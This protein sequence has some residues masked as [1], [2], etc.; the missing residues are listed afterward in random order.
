V[1]GVGTLTTGITAEV[2]ADGTV[3]RG[4]ARVAW[5]VRSG[6]DW[7]VPGGDSKTRQS[8]PHPAPVV[9]TAFR[10][11]NGDAV[12]RVYAV[13]DGDG[14]VVVIEV[15]ND[16][17]E[18]I[19]IGFV[20]E[21]PGMVT[22][23][24][25]GW[26]V[27][28]SLVLVPARRAGAVE[29]DHGLVFPVPHRTK[30]RVALARTPLDVTALADADA[31]ARAWDRMLDRGLR[32][33][34]PEELQDRVDAARV[35]RLLSAPSADAFVALE[36]WGFDEDAAEMWA[37]L[38]M[39]A[40]RAARRASKT[41]AGGLLGDVR[42]ALVAE[43]GA[44]IEFVP[45][46]RTEWLGRNIGAHDIPL[47]RGACSFAVRWHGSRPAVLWD[48]PP[49]STVR[50]PALDPGWSSTEPA[51]EILLAEPPATLL[52]MGEGTFAGT[53]VDAPNEFT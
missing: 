40:R 35:D 47:R 52:A 42:A 36:S 4:A 1:I 18:A 34:L 49:G 43:S 20:L 37:H 46:F 45:G 22:V 5:H 3:H 15:E 21:A 11:A 44:T 13:G 32:T 48:V 30:V 53:A 6:N 41:R 7:L 25:D 14:S 28:G 12:E 17:P 24:V 9:H 10:I 51:G 29:A 38:P 2:D 27:D 19:A 31:V 23:D 8:R 50:V 33:E 16:S 26:R 39:R